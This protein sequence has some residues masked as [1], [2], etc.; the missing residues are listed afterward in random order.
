MTLMDAE[1]PI[2]AG[3]SSAQRVHLWREMLRIRA[4]EGRCNFV[5]QVPKHIS[6]WLLLGT[7]QESVSVAV[8][9]MMGPEDHSIASHRGMGH[10][11]AAGVPMGAILAELMGRAGGLAQGK[12]GMLSMISPVHRHWGSTCL[13]G[14]QTALA[15]GL[16]FGLKYQGKRA[17]AFC[18]LGDGAMNQGV[19][20]EAFN[21]A[22][23]QDLPVIFILENNQYAMGS[24]VARSSALGPT[25]CLAGRAAGYGM[26]WDLCR[27][28]HPLHIRAR[29]AP[30]LQRAYDQSRPTLIEIPTYRYGGF[31]IA[32]AAH[33]GGYRTVEDIEAH[34]ARDAM[35]MYL[36]ELRTRG[37]LTDQSVAQI[38]EEVSTELEA[39]FGGTID[40]P[41]PSPSSLLEHVYADPTAGTLIFGDG[42]E[43]LPKGTDWR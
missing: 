33:K 6:G 38:E 36:R 26:D 14:S 5:Y 15:C 39:V 10:A 1:H 11:L 25:G 31:I 43:A 40:S 7:G 42:P 2:N 9:S 28:D 17:T 8:R 16:A 30:A 27:S 41:W 37:D 20:H 35:D 18:F 22:S 34:R 32:D 3:M 24:S 4:F 21:L 29:L 19:V 12:A 13:A 23:L